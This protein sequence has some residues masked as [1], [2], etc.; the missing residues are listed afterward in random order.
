MS[1]LKNTK[2]VLIRFASKMRQNIQHVCEKKTLDSNMKVKF[3]HTKS[4]V[5]LLFYIVLFL[6]LALS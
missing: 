2:F 5:E 4:M 1:D 3:D 6:N